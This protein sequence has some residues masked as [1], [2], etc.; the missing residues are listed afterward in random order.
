MPHVRH[1]LSAAQRADLWL[2][3]KRGESLSAIGRALDRVP[4][5]IA[6]VLRQ[7]GGI[8][9]PPP[10]RSARVLSTDER[11]EISR[12]LARGESGRSISR[13][14]RRAPSTVCREINRHGGVVGY[15]AGGADAAAW[16]AAQRP[17]P[18]RLAAQPV[19]RRLVASQLAAKW[20]PE[21][22]AGWLRVT[23]PDDP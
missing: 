19:L 1:R 12:G 22:I 9:R 3:W 6:Y 7:Q 5:A 18:C 14:L 10:R 2:R 20:S 11:E 8:V 23:Y 15:R 21:Q 17:K 4:S 13:R 16:R